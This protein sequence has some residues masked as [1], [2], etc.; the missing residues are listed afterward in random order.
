M[1]TAAFEAR[2]RKNS[3][4]QLYLTGRRLG[5][6]VHVMTFTRLPLAIAWTLAV[7]GIV[8]CVAGQLVVLETDTAFATGEGMKSLHAA[9]LNSVHQL[10]DRLLLCDEAEA[11]QLGIAGDAGGGRLV[12]PANQAFTLDCPLFLENCSFLC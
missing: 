2:L 12:Q 3:V 1:R 5:P 6:S 4:D 7:I 9:T 10:P 11:P 8:C